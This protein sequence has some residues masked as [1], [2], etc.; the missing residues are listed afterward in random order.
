MFHNGDGA[1][2]TGLTLAAEGALYG[3]ATLGGENGKG[4]IFRVGQEGKG[5]QILHVFRSVD[6]QNNTNEGGG[7]PGDAPVFGHDSALYGM[8]NIGGKYG[9]GTIYRMTMDGKQF[10]IQHH[11]QRKGAGSEA[12]GAFP[13]GPLTLSTDS[14]LYGSAGQ[15]GADDS[16]VLFKIAQ[17][18]TGFAVLHTFSRS[19]DGSADGWLPGAAPLLGK[20]GRLYGVT[21][22]GGSCGVGTLFW[23]SCDGSKFV[24]MH[25][26]SLLDAADHNTEGASPGAKLTQGR[27]GAIYGVVQGGGPNG[28]GTVFRL[29]PPHAK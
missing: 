29:V 25:D 28:T 4:L 23:A 13:E 20:D 12:N 2:P 7:L 27:D 21:G 11:F 5:F 17:D 19:E 15:G 24:V 3:A 10:A 9:C 22:V 14:F 6:A 8:T 16:G 26:F 1:W 18:G